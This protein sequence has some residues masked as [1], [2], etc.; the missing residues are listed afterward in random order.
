M[1][2]NRY[3]PGAARRLGPA[4]VIAIGSLTLQG[5]Q[6]NTAG[7]AAEV[8][9][10]AVGATT[11][12]KVGVSDSNA[13]VAE[14][15]ASPSLVKANDQG[16]S[17]LR[18]AVS[19]ALGYSAKVRSTAADLALAGVDVDIA[20]AGYHPTFQSSAGIGTSNTGDYRIVLSQ[21]LYD[22][23]HTKANVAGARSGQVAAE[24]DLAAEREKTALDAAL[25]Y[26]AVNR[27]EALVGAAVDNLAVYQRIA[28]LAKDRTASGIGDA[29]EVE[30]AGVHTGE[31]E[32]ALEDA[33]GALRNARSVYSSRV[34]RE[35]DGL[36]SAPELRLPFGDKEGAAFTAS[37]IPAVAAARAREEAARHAMESERAGLLPKLSAEAFVRAEDDFGD[38]EEGVGLRITS[39]TFVGL[40][41]FRRV[42]ASRLQAESAGWAA[43]TARRDA[44]RQVQEYQDREPTLR[45]RLRILGEQL[46]RA[47]ALR[48]FYEDQFKIGERSVSDLVN[49]QADIFRI[50]RSLINARFDILDLQ[51]GAVGALG[52]L[53]KTLGVQGS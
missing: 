14:A 4:A 44:L 41:N 18:E 8:G 43:E 52:T 45:E 32:S 10:T 31:A 49:V 11:A 17:T 34:G 21:P 26:I 33:R 5:C 16:G 39:P 3:L 35:A 15:V 38:V 48:D 40:S 9:K 2:F 30:L 24:A 25:A 22:W 7:S 36:A 20:R 19:A 12:T 28:G 29:S 27:G 47:Q 37:E 6:A 42:D 1:N 23:G 53:Q 51:Y 50:E 13:K 46:K